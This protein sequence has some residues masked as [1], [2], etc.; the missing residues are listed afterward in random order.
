MSATS[1]VTTIQGYSH[2]AIVATDVDEVRRFYC[3]LLGFEELPR[4]DFG[5][6]GVWLRVGDLQLHV[7][8]LKDGGPDTSGARH[9]AL[10]VP[11]ESFQETMDTLKAA[12][13]EFRGEP[14]TREDFGKTVLAAMINDPFGN[15]IEL[16]DI[17]PL[18]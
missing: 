14:R 10:Y 13:V 15:V 3:D 12:G 17:G 5:I 6:P 16:T 7:I 18:G 9:F 2:L 4:P 8:E 11:T 1:T